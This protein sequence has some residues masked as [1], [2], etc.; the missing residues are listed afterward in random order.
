MSGGCNCH[1]QQTDRQKGGSNIVRMHWQSHDKTVH[2]KADLG[3]CVVVKEAG[4]ELCA[5]LWILV[6][7][8]VYAAYL[9][10]YNTT[11]STS[12]ARSHRP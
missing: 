11:S 8:S 7:S 6:V 10:H 4:D 2:S 9:W 1:R 12:L 3:A 5:V